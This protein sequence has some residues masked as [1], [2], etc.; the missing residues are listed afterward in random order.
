M[1]KYVQVE[2]TDNP[3]IEIG[4]RDDDGRLHPSALYISMREGKTVLSRAQALS[5]AAILLDSVRETLE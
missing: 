1:P 3:R 4:T 2:Y 5:L